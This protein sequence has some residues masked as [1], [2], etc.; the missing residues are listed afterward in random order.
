MASQNRLIR[1]LDQIR[2]RL[3]EAPRALAYHEGDDFE[4]WKAQFKAKILDL[5]GTFPDS[6]PLNPEVIEEVVVDD[7]ADAGIPAFTQQKLVYDS[8]L[9]ASVVAYLLVPRDIEPGE[10]RPAILNAH[11]HGSGKSEMVGLDPKCYAPGSDAPTVSAAALHLVKEGFV[12][13]VP[14]WRPFGERLLDPDFARAGRDPCNVAYMG[15]GYFGYNLLALNIWDARRSLD[16]LETL[17][18]VDSSRI[19]M[20]GLSYGGTMTT[21]VT[22]LDERIKAAVV[23]GYCST[24]N[25]ALSL[26][27]K[28]NYCGS[29]YLPGLLQW[30]DIPDVLGLIAPRPLLIESGSLDDCFIIEDTTRAYNHLREIYAAAGA[31]DNLD[32]DIAEVPH[33]Y[34]FHKLVP[35][36]QNH[37]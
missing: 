34:V 10:R 20:V 19:G 6:V 23:S 2:A 9:Y 16:L 5:L 4:T 37:L 25:D 29:Q 32:R 33:Q 22:A 7:F 24:L 35:F 8:E 14:D 27:S 31:I 21:F 1:A 13:L 28:G 30:G 18:F 11:G 17:P 15:F 3:A 26:R 36:L 12:V